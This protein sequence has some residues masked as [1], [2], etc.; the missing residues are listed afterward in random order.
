[1]KKIITSLI[2]VL[3]LVSCQG[4]TLQ[5]YIIDNKSEDDFLSLDFSLKTFV[6]NFDGLPAEQKEI[7]DDV[8]K[9]NLLVLKKDSTQGVY[10]TAKQ[11]ELST[12]LDN[13]FG[14][15]QLMSVNY[16]SAKMKM[17]AD[18]IDGPVEEIVLFASDNKKGFV[19]ARLLGDDLNPSNFYKLMK[20]YDK[21]DM[22]AI[23]D[24]VDLE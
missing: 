23:M 16:E 14:E 10:F 21:M 19:V 2:L 20:M 12:I 4:P 11:E 9:V 18:N 5:S 17:Y 22:E 1:M 15:N 6:D 24:M 8:R 13:Q 3:I 7:F